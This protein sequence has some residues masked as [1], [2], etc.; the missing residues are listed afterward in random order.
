MKGAFRIPLY[1]GGGSNPDPATYCPANGYELPPDPAVF[2]PLNGYKKPDDW[3]PGSDW[4]DPGIPSNNQIILLC[5]DEQSKKLGLI[6]TISS[7]GQYNVKIYGYNN[8]LLS[9]T[10]TNNNTAFSYTFTFGSGVPSAAGYSTYR[11]IITP[12]NPLYNILTFTLSAVSGYTTNWCVYQAKFNIPSATSLASAFTGNT[13]IQRIEFLSNM[14]LLTTLANLCYNAST[15]SSVVF[16]EQMNLLNSFNNTFYGTI[17]EYC[18]VP[19]TLPELAD[20]SYMFYNTPIR[21]FTFPPSLP[22]TTNLAAVFYNCFVF[23]KVVLFTY[24]PIVTNASAMFYANYIL[25]TGLLFPNMPLLTTITQICTQCKLVPSVIFTGP[26]NVLTNC[27]NAFANMLACIVITM[28]SSMSATTRDWTNAFMNCLKLR[29]LTLPTNLAGTT[30]TVLNMLVY[31][32]YVEEITKCD[33]WP[34]NAIDFQWGSTPR[35]LPIWDQPTMKISGLRMPGPS[36]SARSLLSTVNVDWVGST[37]ITNQITLSNT[38]I[39]NSEFNRIFNAIAKYPTAGSGIS[40][41]LNGSIEYSYII[42]TTN[43]TAGSAVLMCS[44]TSSL[45]VGMDLVNLNGGGVTTGRAVT[46]QDAGNTITLANHGFPAG[47]KMCFKTVVTTT[48]I[49][50]H[51]PYYIINTTTNT[52]QISLTEGGNP[53]ELTSDGTGIILLIP[54]ITAITPNVNITIDIPAPVSFNGNTFVGS[55][56]LDRTTAWLKGYIVY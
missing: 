19:T 41:D 4:I 1:Q 51:V 37:G 10:N 28:P 44:N 31:S 27:S 14:N 35:F 47:K 52:F 7:A 54:K 12:T 6:C 2:C 33:T 11:V 48:G 30:L 45:V 50:F 29:K 8:T 36:A 16:P 20:W 9:N 3:T 22:K 34:A 39:P 43:A 49:T 5:S 24:A 21:E 46:I 38:S 32:D 13:Y 42:K 40:I 23:K 55:L 17:I 15:F 26:S 56:T 53:I 18:I 25:N